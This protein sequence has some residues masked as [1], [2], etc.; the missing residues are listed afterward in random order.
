MAKFLAKTLEMSDEE[1]GQ[2][3]LAI[4]REKM[5]RGVRLTPQIRREIGEGA[6]KLGIKF[7]RAMVFAEILA[8]ETLEKTFEPIQ[9]TATK[10]KKYVD[11]SKLG[12]AF[13]QKD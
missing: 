3:A 2:I 8:R 4:V 5:L 7:E 11:A 10:G 12:P 13:T 9:P 6:K 1:M